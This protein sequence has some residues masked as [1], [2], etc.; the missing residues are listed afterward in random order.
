MFIT[1]FLRSFCFKLRS[2]VWSHIELQDDEAKSSML[3]LSMREIMLSNQE[4]IYDMPC[5]FSQESL[6]TRFLQNNTSD[7]TWRIDH[8][9]SSHRYLRLSFRT[10]RQNENLS[11]TT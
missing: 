6:A 11:Q 10:S 8:Y 4:A 9:V 5:L 2:R 3:S 7:L 1:F